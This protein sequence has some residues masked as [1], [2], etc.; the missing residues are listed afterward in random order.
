MIISQEMLQNR[1]YT[2]M[3]TQFSELRPEM[4]MPE[5]VTDM[6]EMMMKAKPL[7]TGALVQENGDVLFRIIA[8]EAKKVSVL[9][10]PER[11]E[12]EL[13]DRG[14]GVWEA[15]FPF[16][17]AGP[18]ATEWR[19][20]G[21]YVL[22]P[23]AP[24]YYSYSH[25][26]NYVDIPDVEMDYVLIKDVPHGTVSH[27]YF[28]SK[29]TEN[30]ESCVVYTPP[31]YE[32]GTEKYPILYLQHGAGEGETSWI[33]NGKAN[34][35]LD[36]L[37]AEGKCKPFIVVMNNGMIRGKNEQPM[38]MRSNT[39]A[40]MLLNDCKPFI[41]AKYRV[42]GDKWNRAMAGLSMGSM[43]T[44]AIGMTHPEL[45]GYLGL[46]SG[47][48][49]TMGGDESLE[50]QPHLKCLQDIE[51]FRADFKVFFRG[52]G[53]GDGFW[54]TFAQDDAICERFGA[55]PAHLDTHIRKTY[56]G[57]HDWNVWRRCI[58]DFAQLI[59]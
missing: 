57:V 13:A 11:I 8:K 21:T 22:H 17:F 37:I 51:K 4:L 48:M 19:V 20:D 53:E 14:D 59:F 9:I 58:H 43:Q 32:T 31:G 3:P 34:F 39:F 47:F 7:P 38:S 18:K 30:F 15:L 35:I 27:E 52:M 25:P 5:G 46:F 29:A 55:D 50:A 12:I 33:W 6:R 28:W 24:I 42:I 16:Q 40:E 44:S 1:A 2:S 26:V 49:R 56:P 41:E 23:Y 45:F 54:D 10:Q 36:N